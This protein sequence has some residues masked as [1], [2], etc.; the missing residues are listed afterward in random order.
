MPPGSI[1]AFKYLKVVNFHY[2][3]QKTIFAAYLEKW[4]IT[5]EMQHA[6][7]VLEEKYI[8]LKM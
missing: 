7:E 4:V 2:K 8:M 6:A 5:T 1:W 3:Y